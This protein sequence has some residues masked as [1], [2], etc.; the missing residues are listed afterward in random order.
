[1]VNNRNSEK[2]AWNL[3]LR[4]NPIEHELFDETVIST[5][6]RQRLKPLRP[7]DQAESSEKVSKA[8]KTR[9][10]ELYCHFAWYHDDLQRKDLIKMG[11]R[12]QIVERADVFRPR[13]VSNLA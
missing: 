8:E 2:A 5:H 9:L 11:Y 7:A 10:F 1:M 13:V 3:C 12:G 4:L 6:F